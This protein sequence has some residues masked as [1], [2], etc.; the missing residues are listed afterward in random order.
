[1]GNVP[2]AI[3]RLSA[4]YKVSKVRNVKV[5]NMLKINLKDENNVF[6]KSTLLNEVLKT[7][8]L[9]NSEIEQDKN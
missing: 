8:I 2:Q 4:V 3:Y 7:I 1:V 9:T 6:K 5:T